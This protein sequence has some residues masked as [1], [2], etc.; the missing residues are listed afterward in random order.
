MNF[1][2]LCCLIPYERKQSHVYK[3]YSHGA[4][5]TL[6]MAVYTKNTTQRTQNL[7]SLYFFEADG[8]ELAVP[9]VEAVPFCWDSA[10]AGRLRS[11]FSRGSSA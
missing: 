9:E 4:N 1:E 7:K 10:P 2:A 11:I 3:L 6:K 5:E 8:P